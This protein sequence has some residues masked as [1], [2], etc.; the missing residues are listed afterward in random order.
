MSGTKRS[1]AVEMWWKICVAL[2]GHL[3]LQLIE[4]PHSTLRE[5]AAKLSVSHETI[6]TILT[7]HLG[8]KHVAARLISKYLNFLQKLNGMRVAEDVLERINSDLTVMKRIV[9]SDETW[10]YEFGMQT[11]HSEWCLPSEPKPKKLHQSGQRV[12]HV[13]FSLDYR[14]ALEIRVLRSN[15][16]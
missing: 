6:R 12:S 11:S 16:K 7:N 9:T 4:S 13:D 2:A 1:K 5:I 15:D 14:G 8:K 3:R 10:V